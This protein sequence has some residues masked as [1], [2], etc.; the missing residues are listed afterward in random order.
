MKQTHTFAGWESKQSSPPSSRRPP[1]GPCPV[2]VHPGGLP[3]GMSVPIQME[4][5]CVLMDAALVLMNSHLEVLT[6]S[7]LLLLSC[8][9]SLPVSHFL[10]NGH[11]H[12]GCFSQSLTPCRQHLWTCFLQRV[13]ESLPGETLSCGISGTPSQTS[14]PP[15]FLHEP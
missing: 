10:I 11:W 2:A 13:G 8:S 7:L 1:Q 4:G 14:P 3:R 12:C 15:H 5:V 6:H 9:G